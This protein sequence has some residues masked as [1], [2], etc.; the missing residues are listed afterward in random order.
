MSTVLKSSVQTVSFPSDIMFRVILSDDVFHTFSVSDGPSRACQSR[1][2]PDWAVACC[3]HHRRFEISWIENI[4]M[5][6][7]V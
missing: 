7:H 4:G 3:A 1:I 6:L 2:D 5:L